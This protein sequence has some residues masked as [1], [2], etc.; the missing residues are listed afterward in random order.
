MSDEQ[1]QRTLDTIDE[2]EDEHGDDGRGDG[3][4]PEG[5]VRPNN[6]RKKAQTIRGILPRGQLEEQ[7]VQLMEQQGHDRAAVQEALQEEH[8]AARE[9]YGKLC[10]TCK[11]HRSMQQDCERCPNIAK[12]VKA[13]NPTRKGYYVVFVITMAQQVYSKEDIA[14]QC[15]A[16]EADRLI[17]VEEKHK[18]EDPHMHIA[19]QVYGKKA[20]MIRSWQRWQ[21]RMNPNMK[22]GENKHLDVATHHGKGHAMWSWEQACNYLMKPKKD[23]YVDPQPWLAQ[24]TEDGYNTDVNPHDIYQLTVDT[25]SDERLK[26]VANL[27][28]NHMTHKEV[29]EAIYSQ[30]FVQKS[31][32]GEEQ[33]DSGMY[34]VLMEYYR[35][36]QR[37]L[38]QMNQPTPYIYRWQY[39]M[40]AY[41]NGYE[42]LMDNK[43]RHFWLRLPVSAGKTWFL[44]EMRDRYK[45]KIYE[46]HWRGTKSGYE[47]NSF[48]F[49]QNQPFVFFDELTPHVEYGR[50]GEE[51]EI[52][53]KSFRRLMKVITGDGVLPVLFGQIN[54]TTAFTKSIIIVASN[55]HCP[56]EVIDGVDVFEERFVTVNTAKKRARE[57]LDFETG[58][59]ADQEVARQY[60]RS[61]RQKTWTPFDDY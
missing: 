61:K 26:T 12:A 15:Y 10:S 38:P 31:K 28:V 8:D 23:K 46:P 48:A 20:N 34:R 60:F 32:D 21:K 44:N 24:K 5:D 19:I 50:N 3:S 57:I 47:C 37:Q 52:W 11:D 33:L 1:I 30:S 25:T 54:T 17:I 27:A 51:I 41:L 35:E 45:G 40:L 42:K 59:L 55:Y 58:E 6:K 56:K 14:K 16:M 7:S 49:Y 22:K 9:Y 18:D 13:L 2:A 36:V 39:E 4:H 29:M 53:D 43:R